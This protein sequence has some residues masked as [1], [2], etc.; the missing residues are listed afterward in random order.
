MAHAYTIDR[1]R[2]VVTH[3]RRM[4]LYA[5]GGTVMRPYRINNAADRRV[6]RVGVSPER[7]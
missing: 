3:V 7:I 5:V 2:A 1:K 4:R 6:F